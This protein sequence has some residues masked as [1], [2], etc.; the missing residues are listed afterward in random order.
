MIKLYFSFLILSI[1]FKIKHA[2][3][4][5]YLCR[6][7]PE[8]R[9]PP[10]VSCSNIE[11][12]TDFK[13]DDNGNGTQQILTVDG[14]KALAIRTDNVVIV[15]DAEKQKSQEF[16]ITKDDADTYTLKSYGKC[17]IQ[18]ESSYKIELCKRS[19]NQLFINVE[20]E[21]KPQVSVKP[22]TTVVK[23]KPTIQKVS[24]PTEKQVKSPTIDKSL[25]DKM[26]KTLDETNKLNRKILKSQNR[27][28]IISRVHTCHHHFYHH[29][30]CEDDEYQIVEKPILIKSEHKAKKHVYPSEAAT[31]NI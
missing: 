19:G 18:K 27:H 6:K 3:K 15:N 29:H 1:Q 11:E 13:F 2:D 20:A 21:I 23:P 26:Q 14:T 30:F 7:L 25:L 5:I 4:D 31:S 17:V 8:N 12:A 9:L 24:N 10:I 22:K 28:S 16:T